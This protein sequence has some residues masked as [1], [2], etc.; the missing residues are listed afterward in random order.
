MTMDDYTRLLD[1]GYDIELVG[2]YLMV[3][4]VPYV[5]P[6]VTVQRGRLVMP[7]AWAGDR[8]TT[9]PNH[10]A[11][12]AGDSPCDS[13]G[14]PLVKII[15]TRQR[16]EFIPGMQTDFYLSSKPPSGNYANYFDK[17]TTYVELIARWAIG[18]DPTVS[19]RTYP[20]R[21]VG[22]EDSPFVYRDSASS[23]AGITNLTSVFEEM[24]IAIVGLGGTGSHI[25]DLV[26][27]TP[28][29]EIHIYDGDVFANHNAFRAPGAADVDD[30]RG[31]PNKAEYW[32]RQYGRMKHGIIAHADFFE[33][34]MVNEIRGFNFVFLALD[35]DSDR[36]GIVNALE[37]AGLSFIDVGMGI[38]DTGDGL[39]GLLRVS[40]STPNR[41]IEIPGGASTPD[42]YARNIQIADLNALNAALAVTHWKRHLGFYADVTDG[43][44]AFAY[45]VS[46]NTITGLSQ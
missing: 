15:N 4:D 22:S 39:T 21:T 12:F 17:V 27:K 19:A 14:S 45:P 44:T 31:T 8:L 30:L 29:E 20:P 25:L 43:A 26:A 24:R 33:A 46:D 37:N 18:I 5:T 7:A 42:D 2:G 6:S 41:R 16:H 38:T 9:P 1:E 34:A 11:H 13:T 10:T 32:A 35:D 3:N 40:A 36:A 23:R 28:V